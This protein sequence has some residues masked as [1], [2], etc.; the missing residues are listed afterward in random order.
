MKIKELKANLQTIN[1]ALKLH[2]KGLFAGL[3][4]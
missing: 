4:S 1:E 2:K 3:F